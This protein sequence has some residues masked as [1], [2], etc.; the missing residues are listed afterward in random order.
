[1]FVDFSLTDQAGK[2]WRLSDHLDAAAALVFLRGDWW[3]YCNGQLVS[4]AMRHKEI[5]AAGARLF[6]VSVDSPGRN[7]ALV[8]KLYLPFPVLSDPDRS[9]AISPYGVA[10]EKDA[11]MIARPA[12][13]VVT[14]AREEAFRIVSRDFADR[15]PE[16]ELLAALERLGLAATSQGSPGPGTPEP[17]SGSLSLSELRI[18]FRGARF[19]AQ[20]MGLRHA[21]FADEIKFDSKKY[22]AGMDRFTAALDWLR[23]QSGE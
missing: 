4:L 18:Y 7:A 8:E 15:L 22:V 9:G 12:I 20:A 3:P 2:S 16:D 14:P 17:G 19:A 6:A 13:L 21:H 5:L 11:R 23:Q 10:D 1:M